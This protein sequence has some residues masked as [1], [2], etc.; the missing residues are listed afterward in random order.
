MIFLPLGYHNENGM[1]YSYGKA[2]KFCFMWGG[3]FILLCLIASLSNYREV[4]R[5]NIY[6]F[7]V[8]WF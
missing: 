4:K 5:K 7:L 1:I 8:S 6:Q 2:A 3:I